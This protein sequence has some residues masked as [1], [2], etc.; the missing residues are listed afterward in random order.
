MVFALTHLSLFKVSMPASICAGNPIRV[1]ENSCT[2]TY[3]FWLFFFPFYYYYCLSRGY[4]ISCSFNMAM[5]IALSIPS[6]MPNFPSFCLDLNYSSQ[7]RLILP[8]F[9]PVLTYASSTLSRC[10][11]TGQL[12]YWIIT[13]PFH[14]SSFHFLIGLLIS[15]RDS[16]TYF[17]VR[18]A[19][20]TAI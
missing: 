9:F 11:G 2:V 7:L 5:L 1:F 19:K 18:E 20:R 14:F 13:P 10:T 12:P 15:K 6:A 8:L 16:P 4:L 3:E 17:G